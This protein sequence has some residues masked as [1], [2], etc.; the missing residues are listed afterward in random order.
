MTHHVSEIGERYYRC[1]LI[2]DEHVVAHEEVF[3]PDDDAAIDKAREILESSKFLA[4]EVWRGTERVASIAKDD[5]FFLSI[6]GRLEV[7]RGC[8]QQ[9]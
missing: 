7:G 1:Y 9:S 2:K 3:R 4:I 6:D 5:R 8:P